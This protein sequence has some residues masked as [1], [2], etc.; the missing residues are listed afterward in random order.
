MCSRSAAERFLNSGVSCA[1]NA[2]PSS[3]GAEPARSPPS[4]VT[5]PALG[6]ASPTE[7]L[8][9][10]DFPAPFGPT[11]ATTCPSGIASVQS[12]NAVAEP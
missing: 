10:V 9:K 6:A 8:S 3:A 4:T 7:R 1:T 12:R 11:S 2:I 5:S